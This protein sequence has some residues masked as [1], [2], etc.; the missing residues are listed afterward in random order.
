MYHMTWKRSEFKIK[1]TVSC[2]QE[3]KV[4]VSSTPSQGIW[5]C[6]ITESV[7]VSRHSK[8]LSVRSVAQSCPTLCDP[9]DGST[10]DFP[11][12]HQLPE[13]AQTPV[14]QVG[15]ATP[16]QGSAHSQTTCDH[17]DLAQRQ[18]RHWE[19]EGPREG[20]SAPLSRGPGVSAAS[21]HPCVVE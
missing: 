11:V 18:E 9:L 16:T 1:R 12:H 6:Q 5:M 15:D 4:R 13:P 17:K 19:E 14:H 8:A 10:P 20:L 2:S 7:L 21:R 3:C